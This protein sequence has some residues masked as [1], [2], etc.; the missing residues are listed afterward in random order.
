GTSGSGKSTLGTQLAQSL[1]IPFIDGDDL[2]PKSNIEKMSKGIPLNDEDRLPWLLSIPGQAKQSHDGQHHKQ[3][4]V[5]QHKYNACVIACS[6]LKRSYRHLLRHGLS[7]SESEANLPADVDDHLHKDA[8]DV[9]HVYLKVS[10][11]E[12]LRRMHERAGHFM[13]ED[14]LK[15]QLATLEDPTGEP[16]T[17]VLDDGPVQ[18]LVEKGKDFFNS[19]L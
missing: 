1:A 3:S 6:A 9:Y 19:I 4:D 18:N 13:K 11:E 10:P 8:L 17:L 7:E 5:S 12:L 2:H 14:M 16:R 15:S